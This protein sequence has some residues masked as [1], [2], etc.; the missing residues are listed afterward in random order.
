MRSSEF[1][2]EGV[3]FTAQDFLV[4]PTVVKCRETI[5]AGHRAEL[6]TDEYLAI[7]VTVAIEPALQERFGKRQPFIEFPRAIPLP[8]GDG[9][10]HVVAVERP[11]MKLPRVLN[12]IGANEQTLC[13]IPGH[14]MFHDGK[15]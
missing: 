4:L 11:E 13:E 6:G 14:E 2:P 10:L 5:A 15:M 8:V 1:S 12:Q 3:H 9:H 7:C